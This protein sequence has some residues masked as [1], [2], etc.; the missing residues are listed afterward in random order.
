M[1]L[2][3][4]LRFLKGYVFFCLHGSFPERLINVASKNRI[5]VWGVCKRNGVFMGYTYVS[6]YRDLAQVASELK[7]RTKV[8]KRVGLPFLVNRYKRRIGIIV[9][10][11]LLTV[12]IMVMQN[13]V[14][15]IE[16]SGNEAI[17]T[18]QI[19]SVVNEYG[20]RIG[21]FKPT[22]N[23]KEIELIM[24]T[25]F[26]GVSWIAVN[27]KGSR[28]CIEVRE[29]ELP[30]DVE[31][32]KKPCNIIATKDGQIVRIETYAG[33]AEVKVQDAVVEGQMLVNGITEDIDGNNIF[34]HA[35]A[36]VIAKVTET[37]EI[38]VPIRGVKK[39]YTG[40]IK[41]RNKL[42]LF[43]FRFPLYIG[44]INKK[45]SD[46]FTNYDELVLFGTTMPFGI[47]RNE[48]REYKQVD[49]EITEKEA[50]DK[51]AKQWE[52]FEKEG[53]KDVI[54]LEKKVEK[55]VVG[56]EYIMTIIYICEENIGRSE[57]ILIEDEK[58]N[59][60]SA[61]ELAD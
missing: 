44:G 30:P 45:N 51:A 55:E 54:L 61:P 7:I 25:R 3:K 31:N 40:K 33:Q 20:I 53:M 2:I 47:E 14:W 46:I 27:H 11:G 13:F 56:D 41:K 37:K 28:V 59:E 17:P 35:A 10:I 21:T 4:L 39:E 6:Q 12:F 52:E 58:G 32:N 19:L 36:K 8:Q 57:L 22:T 9:G 29:A 49:F 26:E 15:D 23:F 48:G 43:G 38:K 18:E 42:D 60:I 50:E 16:V 24:I 34:M 1:Y 5:S